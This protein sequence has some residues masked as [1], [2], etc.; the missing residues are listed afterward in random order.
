[1]VCDGDG[2]DVCGVGGG[3]QM[4]A[5]AGENPFKKLIEQMEKRKQTKAVADAEI[6]HG[7]R[8]P[9]APG[10]YKSTPV[11]TYSYNPKLRKSSPPPPPPPSPSSR[12]AR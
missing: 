3:A 7:H 9:P 12:P 4:Q 1:M 6:L 10:S 8:P 11:N 2:H 5:K